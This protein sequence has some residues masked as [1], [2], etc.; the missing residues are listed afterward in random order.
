[1]TYICHH[2]PGITPFNI[3]ALPLDEWCLF[4]AQ[5]DVELAAI[6]KANKD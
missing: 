1:M 2:W 5:A 6:R 3:W 4:A